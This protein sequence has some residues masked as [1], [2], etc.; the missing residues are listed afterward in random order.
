MILEN[1]SNSKISNDVLINVDELEKELLELG[2]VECPVNH[3]FGPNIY[4]REVF[5]KAGTFAIG[6]KQKNEHLNV[7]L[8]GSVA[9]VK[10]DGTVDVLKA[11]L[12]YVGKPGRKVGYVLEDCRWQNIYSTSETD[13]E[14]LESMFIE[15]SEAWINFEQSNKLL[16][17]NSCEVDRKD[18][19][20]FLQQINVSETTA[21]EQ[22]E[23]KS[24]QIE[25]PEQFKSSVFVRKSN[26][27][28]LGVFVTYPAISG[29]IIAPARI[30]G[31]RTPVGRYTNHSKNP[32]AVFV[33]DENDDIWLVLKKDIAGCV[34]GNDGE[35][36][37]VDYREAI[38]LS[39]DKFLENKK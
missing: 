34:G 36:I 5:L 37:T 19:F 23:N 31:M 1:Q 2:Q 9:V 29:S 28:G 33:K 16:K 38:S 39:C 8:T 26:I 11:P 4:I 12:M 27:E 30:N 7:M 6:H 13:I 32:N 15:K 21:R 22:S 25:M 24:D 35:E 17:N 20:D 3:Y 14:K 18:F 10:D